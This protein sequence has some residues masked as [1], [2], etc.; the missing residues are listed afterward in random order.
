M[1][2]LTESQSDT[3]SIFLNGA[4]NTDPKTYRR[5]KNANANMP[6]KLLFALKVGRNER[7]TFLGADDQRGCHW[8]LCHVDIMK[9]KIVYGDS[10]AWPFPSGFLCRVDKYLKAVCKDD[11]IS[12][13]SVVMLHDPQNQCPMSG[14]HRCGDTCANFYPLQTCSNI[15]GI[16]VMVIGAIACYNFDFFQHLSTTHTCSNATN[17]PPI[18]LQTPTRF[19]KYLRLVVAS[20]FASNSVNVDYVVPRYWKQQDH[21]RSSSC[22]VT[23]PP[24]LSSCTENIKRNVFTTATS[25]DL[26]KNSKD[27]SSTSTKENLGKPVVLIVEDKNDHPASPLEHDTESSGDFALPNKKAALTKKKH[28]KCSYC[29]SMFTRKFTLKRRTQKEHTNEQSKGNCHCHDCGY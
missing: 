21:D 20:W 26:R 19:G 22:S 16:V 17:F 8:T 3:Y 10:L 29:D 11:D 14:M 15:C 24:L 1:K 7:G 27:I 25:H 28:L 12:N 23:A 4:L 9:K 13:Y 18:F 5:F 2:T 6:S